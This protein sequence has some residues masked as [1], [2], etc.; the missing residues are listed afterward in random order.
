MEKRIRF[1]KQTTNLYID[2]SPLKIMDS[3]YEIYIKTDLSKYTGKWVAICNEGIIAIG[4]NAKLV[5]L[6]AQEKYPNKKIMLIKVP[7]EE[8]LIF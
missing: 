5:Y 4:D 7:E 3:N 8:S 1:L 2:K 6:E